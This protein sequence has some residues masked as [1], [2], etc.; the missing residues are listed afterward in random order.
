MIY[1]IELAIK[2]AKKEKNKG[3]KAII[4]S[5]EENT[6]CTKLLLENR[7]EVFNQIFYYKDFKLSC[8]LLRKSKKL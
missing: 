6:K 2:Q 3:I 1:S 7:L 4:G 8:L 5:W